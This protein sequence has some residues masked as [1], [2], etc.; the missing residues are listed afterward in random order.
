MAS[1]KAVAAESTP[2]R[3]GTPSL[4]SRW[5]V[6]PRCSGKKPKTRRLFAINQRQCSLRLAQGLIV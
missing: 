1:S 2:P 6:T 3:G 4:A 5:S